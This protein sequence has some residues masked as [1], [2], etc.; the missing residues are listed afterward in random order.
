MTKSQDNKIGYILAGFHLL[1]F[2]CVI[3]NA[4]STPPDAQYQLIWTIL[5]FPDLPA[6]VLLFLGFASI[7]HT[8]FYAIDDYLSRAISTHPY[9]NFSSFWY[10][11]I[12]YGVLGTLWWFYLPVMMKWIKSF[13]RKHSALGDDDRL[14]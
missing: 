7:P 11:A 8:A 10:P 12:I 14:H 13:F 6:T 3:W 2:A 1:L 5:F 9:N 4:I